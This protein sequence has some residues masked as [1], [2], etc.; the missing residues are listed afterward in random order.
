MKLNPVFQSVPVAVPDHSGFDLSREH[1]FT[2]DVGSLVPAECFEVIP[3]DI[4]SMGVMHKVTFP[5][6]AVP[7][8]GRVDACLEAFFVPSRILW[9]GWQS[10][11]T[12]NFGV[13]PDVTPTSGIPLQVPSIDMTNAQNA[14]FLGAGTLSD[15]LGML[16]RT[17]GDS[18]ASVTAMKHL[19]YHKICDE[20]YRD[21]NNMKP[22]FAK[23]PWASTTVVQ[24]YLN[25]AAHFIDSVGLQTA[26]VQL[27]LY[28][29][30]VADAWAER[31]DS[32]IGLGSLRQRCWA[33]D[34]FTTMTTRPQAGDAA[35][36]RFS[37]SG[38]NSAI[39]V[40]DIRA[41]SALQNW[42]EK[43]NIAGT[44]YGSQIL[45]HFGVVPPDAVLD[46]PVLLGSNRQSVYVG[47]VENNSNSESSD[48]A[49]PFGSTLGTAAGFGS[50]L[51]KGSLIPEFHVKEHGYIFVMFSIV[52]HAYYDTGVERENVHLSVGDFAWPEYAHIGD[53][54]V[55]GEEI[56]YSVRG[57]IIGYNQ[58]YS[59]YKCRI[60]KVSGLL[61]DNQSLSVYALKRGFSDAP[62][63]GKSF[64]EIPNTYLD[65][66][67]SVNNE[68]SQFGAIV[69]CFFDT[70]CIRVL[71]EYSL[72]SL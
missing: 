34:Y 69:D 3:S 39:T 58:R 44:D 37:T 45:S 2:A 57:R 17:S 71:P 16:S 30:T 50:S 43:N 4:V 26:S 49:N 72:P 66:V 32:S 35:E 13:Y 61:H 65:Q 31:V 1:L 5:P 52:P 15:Y 67:S 7:F 68:V 18:F 38:S 24:N 12:Q 21:K 47:S 36:I 20:W 28:P 14:P 22:F 6:F 63:L 9:K 10:F 59:E 46:K 41:A 27:P 54:Q 29:T 33:K 70:K 48:T 60:D 40:S 11:I 64:L 25:Y 23:S 53:Q 55:Y 42:L 51:G 62:A 56:S 8:M 19:A